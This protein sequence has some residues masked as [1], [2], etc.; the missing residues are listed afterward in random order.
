MNNSESNSSIE[1]ERRA[2]AEL[3]CR[4]TKQAQLSLTK[5]ERRSIA[6]DVLLPSLVLCNLRSFHSNVRVILK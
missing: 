2:D 6:V 1:L 4:K 3:R 5:K